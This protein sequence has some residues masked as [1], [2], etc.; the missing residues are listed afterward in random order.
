MRVI[1]AFGGVVLLVTILFDAFQTMILPRRVAQGVRLTRLFYRLSWVLCKTGARLIRPSNRRENYLS[2]YGPLS[3][4]LL[5]VIWAGSLVASF[6]C[7]QWALGSHLTVAQGTPS[8]TTDLYMSGTT[9]FTLGLGDVT[10]N[11]ALARVLTVIEGGTG[12][13]FLAVVIGYLPVLYQAFSRRE[14]SISLLDARAGSPPSAGELLRRLRP[15]QDTGPLV[16]LLREWERWAAEL[17]ESHISFPV[18]A[19]YRSQHDQQS[20]LGALTTI[21]DLSV[22][23]IVGCDGPTAN[24]AQLT[25]AIC[26]H[27]AV[28]LSQILSARPQG[29]SATR[30]P[31]ADFQKLRAMLE[32]AGV[33]ILPNSK[34]EQRLQELRTMYEPYLT[35]LS[36]YLLIALPA[37]VPANGANDDW[38]TSAW[39]HA[40][41]GASS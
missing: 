6:A 15:D 16:E 34:E 35:A 33:F 1:A 30:L 27:A 21:L 29:N 13:G 12:F 9:F 18:L 31:A 37:F 10:P 5:L 40:N 19:Y 22:L 4:L 23:V 36:Q 17:L 26:R 39:E 32:P 25:F 41:P 7:L 11:S 28:D 20:W 38:Q 14:V 3:L 8:L 24:V 2:F